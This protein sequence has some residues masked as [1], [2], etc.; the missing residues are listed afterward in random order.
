MRMAHR[1]QPGRNESIEMETEFRRLVEALPGLVWT[2]LPDGRAE[3]VSRRWSDYT[4]MAAEEAMGLGWLSAI[5]PEDLARVLERW[6]ELLGSD[7]GGEMEARLRR[8][9]G[10]YRRFLVSTVP[11]ADDS[12]R[13]VKWCGI[14]TDIEDRRRAE[15]AERAQ[16]RRFQMVVDGLPAF[17]TL[18]RPDGQ[19]EH[20]SRH[21]LDYFGATLEELNRR[22]DGS[23]FHPDDRDGVLSAWRDSLESEKPFEFEARNRGANGVYRWFQIRGFPLRDEDGGVPLWCF[24]QT[25]VDDARQAEALLAGEVRLLE[26]VARGCPLSEALTSLCKLVETISEGCFCSILIVGPEGE[27]FQVGAGPSLPDGYNALL[28]GKTIDPACGP[29]SLAVTLKAPVITR[30]V[31]T[32]PR[33]SGSIWPPLMAEY[34]LRSC[35]AMP[36]ISGEQKVLGVFATYRG[37]AVSP[38]ATGQELIDRFASTAG[39]IIERALN[40]AALKESEARKAAILNSALDCIITIDEAGAITEFNPA[41]ERTFGF[42]RDEVIGKT[43]ADVLIPPE[44]R[45]RHQE[46]LARHL[47][48][49]ETHVLGNRVEMTA[50]RSDGSEFPIELT[51]TPIALSGPR[52][53]TGYLRDI[54]ERK[55]AEVELKR[56]EAFLKEA[57]HISSIASFSWRVAANQIKWSEQIYRIFEFDP[58]ETVTL[59]LIGTRVHPDDMPMLFDMIERAQSD[60]SDFEYEHRLLM[61]DGS[62]K[63]VHL[64]A[65]GHSDESGNIEYIGAVQEVTE[66]RLAE[67]ALDKVR[68]ELSHVSR[69]ASLG[70]LTASIA[71][72]VNQPLSGIITNASTSLKMLSAEPPNVEGALETARRTIRDGN[73]AADVIKRLRALFSRKVGQIEAVDLNEAAREVIA[74]SSSELQRRQASLRVELA[75]DLPPVAGDRVQLQQVILNLLLN[76]AD[77]MTGVEGRSRQMSLRTEIL[78]DGDVRLSVRDSGDGFDPASAGRL[79]DAFFTTKASGMGI[80]LSIS[81]SIVEAYNGRIEA[82][83]NEGP[84]ATFSFTLPRLN[85]STAGDPGE[86]EVRVSSDTHRF[87]GSE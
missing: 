34:G 23:T 20:A 69:V 1:S 29:C 15:D 27:N 83:L 72:E 64:V 7:N 48:T 49:G 76:A 79:F 38:S 54:T 4:G 66:R 19:I 70:A 11:L 46:G 71:H 67:E 55:T 87:L 86:P 84:G 39:I 61:P 2:A 40:D 25:D 47:A 12:G 63:F 18:T 16:E 52:S 3:F 51:V 35:W 44:F 65:H 22:E 26:N 80:G 9:D 73:R 78:K 10:E 13:V 5:H 57:Q 41:A 74:L 53:F 50:L 28:E 45:E 77:A 81:R 43:L 75:G 62:V 31:T 37:E 58:R 56:S 6:S 17:V 85:A 32:D 59:E 60:A 36:I 8:R 21:V 82:Q 33:W 24:L 14:N 30:D 42:R 68:S